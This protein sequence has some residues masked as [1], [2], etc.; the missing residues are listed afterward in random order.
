MPVQECRLSGAL[1][2]EGRRATFFD[3]RREVGSFAQIAALTGS[4]FVHTGMGEPEQV[5]G[6]FVT[7]L[8]FAFRDADEFEIPAD[9]LAQ[10]DR[11][12]QTE[13]A[14]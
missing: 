1:R 10:F 13:V 3:F 4:N 9:T 6:A 14:L 12:H 11:A 8:V 7:F 5:F 2:G